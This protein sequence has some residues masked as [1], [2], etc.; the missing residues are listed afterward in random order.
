S[1]VDVAAIVDDDYHSKDETVVGECELCTLIDHRCFYIHHGSRS[2]HWEPPWARWRCSLGL[3]YGWEQAIDEQG[4]LYYLDHINERSSY[5]DPRSPNISSGLRRVVLERDESVG[6]GF[7]AAGANAFVVQFVS[8]GGP[9]DGLLFPND[10]IVS[11]NGEN[12][13]KDSKD[14]VV[15]KIRSSLR[16]ITL[17]VEQMSS[18][19][20]SPRRG[21]RVRFTDKVSVSSPD[22]P[23][24]GFPPSIPNVLRV[25]LENGQTRSFKYDAATTVK[26]V[27]S[28]LCDKLQLLSRRHFCL[29]LEYSIGNRSSKLTLLEN[30]VTL[31][32]LASDRASSSTRCVF[33]FAFVPPDP[34][35]L[36]LEDPRSFEYFYSQCLNDVVCGRFA[37]EM[38]YEACIRMAALHMQQI[39]MDSHL[40]KE[41][42]VSLSRMEREL[43]LGTFL[44]TILL[45]N[46]KRSEIRK[47]I[48]FYLKKDRSAGHHSLS[49]CTPR[50]CSQSAGTEEP[51]QSSIASSSVDGPILIRLKYIQ[52]LSH[53]PSFG[54]R[55]FSV[56]FR[57]S[58]VDMMMQVDPRCGIVVRNCGKTV[59]GAAHPSISI[60]FHIISS[61]CVQRASE[62]ISTFILRLNNDTHQGL[63]FLVENNE[64]SE[65]VIH[66]QGYFE[67]Q[68]GRPLPCDYSKQS[69]EE[70]SDHPPPYAS[71]HTVFPSGWNYSSDLS[72]G[73]K[74]FDLR[75]RVPSYEVASTFAQ[76]EASSPAFNSGLTRLAEEEESIPLNGKS[77]VIE[78]PRTLLRATDSLHCK[79]SRRL[80]SKENSSPLLQRPAAANGT[81]CSLA[82]DSSDTEDSSIS[83]AGTQ[84]VLDS[85]SF[86]LSSPDACPTSLSID[87]FLKHN[88]LPLPALDSILLLFPDRICTD[89]EIIDLTSPVEE[90]ST[91]LPARHLLSEQDHR[92]RVRFVSPLLTS[93]RGGEEVAD[94]APSSRLG[95][96]ETFPAETTKGDQKESR[97]E[98]KAE[99][100]REFLQRSNSVCDEEDI[101]CASRLLSG[102][103]TAGVRRMSLKEY[104]GLEPRSRDFS[105]SPWKQPSS[106]SS[107]LSSFSSRRRRCL[108]TEC[109]SPLAPL[110]PVTG[111]GPAT[112]SPAPDIVSITAR[113]E[114]LRLRLSE[115][116]EKEAEGIKD[117]DKLRLLEATRALSGV[118][119]RV[120]REC[121]LSNGLSESLTT[122]AESVV[123]AAETCLAR[124]T[125]V[126]HAQLLIAKVDQ[127]LAS[128]IHSL[129]YFISPSPSSIDSL[130]SSTS[131]AASLSQLIQTVAS[132]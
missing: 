4:R 107:L 111:T 34:Y 122:S 65:L 75:Q 22:T 57:D 6:Y 52:I 49:A 96:S 109:P 12:V 105:L 88:D 61:I 83:E 103:T 130:R 66:I 51:S 108:S 58:Q 129:P 11:V 126:F 113:L 69:R 82:T 53:L 38:R 120:V 40:T 86:G 39:S 3:P 43:G 100:V 10:R 19:V 45:E 131:L 125:T 87:S 98:M 123:A 106:P 28:S 89:R 128:L 63:H 74:I 23:I 29:G 117:E 56:T 54:C 70:N 71:V 119:K 73:E 50:V 1:T 35:A 16:N 92:R 18:S 21:C 101:S 115:E 78:K 33:R 112:D 91:P 68:V 95:R 15:A 72:P 114:I 67:L 59:N 64:L 93:R 41:G 90:E 8:P 42:R 14:S 85:L 124:I 118:S 37:F 27:V 102:G 97:E 44:P 79:N 81:L 9:S 17:H 60:A 5:R 30:T 104:S 121:S 127:V 110:P 62:I 24:A 7:V 31:Q 77:E 36:Y 46:V 2:T 47:H 132:L 116:R 80:H 13:E 76:S 26:D 99:D 48:R 25:F 84:P 32:E 55:S 20:H 94:S